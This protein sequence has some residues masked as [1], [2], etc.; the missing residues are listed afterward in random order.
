MSHRRLSRAPAR[1]RLITVQGNPR[2]QP[3]GRWVRPG[4]EQ[5]RPAIRRV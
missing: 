5:G 3:C 1:A 4:Y 2:G